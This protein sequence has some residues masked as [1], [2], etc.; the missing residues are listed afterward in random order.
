[1]PILNRTR[2]RKR[3]TNL[4]IDS[5]SSVEDT[6]V[7]V[8]VYS[9]TTILYNYA[10]STMESVS[11]VNTSSEEFN[12]AVQSQVQQDIHDI[13]RD[14]TLDSSIS[15]GSSSSGSASGDSGGGTSGGGTG[16]SGLPASPT[17][18]VYATYPFK[19]NLNPGDIQETSFLR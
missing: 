3:E 18:V 4:S 17:L 7:I 9:P 16:G 14:G 12:R 6:P 5:D 2:S 11:A 1:M 19:S 13:I 10:S 15:T 8:V